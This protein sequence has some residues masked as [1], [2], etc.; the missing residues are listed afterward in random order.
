MPLQPNDKTLMKSYLDIN[1]DFAKDLMCNTAQ[2]HD[3]KLKESVENGR[4]FERPYDR[5]L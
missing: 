5:P 1:V 4:G 3:R 2:K